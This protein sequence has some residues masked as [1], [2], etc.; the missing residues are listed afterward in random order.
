[1]DYWYV[2]VVLCKLHLAVA[3]SKYSCC[4]VVYDC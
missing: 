4:T 2:F 1:M 3:K